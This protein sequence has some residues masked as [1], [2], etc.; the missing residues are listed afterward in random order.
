M[1]EILP[2]PSKYQET[3]DWTEDIFKT[4]ERGYYHLVNM[5]LPKTSVLQG[6]V[7]SWFDVKKDAALQFFQYPPSGLSVSGYSSTLPGTRGP[8]SF[9]VPVPVVGSVT[10]RVSA[11][12]PY[13]AKNRRST[14]YSHSRNAGAHFPACQNSAI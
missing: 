12:V 6:F 8:F 4:E 1:R 2:K 14:L 3:A 10:R 11:A 13:C 5:V 9:S 7:T